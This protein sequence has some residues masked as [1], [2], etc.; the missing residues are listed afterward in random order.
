MIRRFLTLRWLVIHLLTVTVVILFVF[1]LGRWQLHRWEDRGTSVVPPDNRPAV[2]LAQLVQPD[3]PLPGGSIGRQTTVTGRFDDAHQV[4]VADRQLGGRNGFWVVSALHPENGTAGAA[5]LVVR[6][7]VP[8]ATDPA[9][10]VPDTSVTVSG[11][12][13]ASE[14]PPPV[15]S[16]TSAPL[17]AGQYR[18]VNTAELTGAFPYR[19]L[20]GYVLLAHTDPPLAG[21]QPTVVPVPIATEN[22]GGGIRNLIYAIQWW[23]FAIAVLYFWGR[24]VRDDLK[25]PEERSYQRKDPW[26]EETDEA[27]QPT[28]D[29]THLP[30]PVPA[31]SPLRED[32]P[33]DAELAAY[34]RWLAELNARSGRS[35]SRT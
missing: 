14:D 10:R 3:E 5:A 28:A 30:E 11:R 31:P 12:L 33:E 26:A 13:Y 15:D 35:R 18:V 21:P 1:F 6:G 20:D 29:R 19:I 9:I 22:N 32:D 7:W 25:P 24:L 34:N 2:S 23:L 4:L 8:T 27:E 17:P 16:G